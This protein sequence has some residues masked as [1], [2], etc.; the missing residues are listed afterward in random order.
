MRQVDNM[1]ITTHLDIVSAEKEIFSG[2]AERVVATGLLGEIG[3]I[4]AQAW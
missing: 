1:A 4:P 2:L 3:V